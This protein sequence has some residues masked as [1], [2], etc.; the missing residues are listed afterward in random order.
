MDYSNDPDGGTTHGRSNLALGSVDFTGLN[1]IY[2]TLDS[3]QLAGTKLTMYSE[4]LYVPGFNKHDHATG[5][6]PEPTA[7]AMLI[8][9]FG[10]TGIAARRHRRATTG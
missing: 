2:K 6:V 4:G 1:V 10:L 7:W 8:A 5:A 3:T 9:G